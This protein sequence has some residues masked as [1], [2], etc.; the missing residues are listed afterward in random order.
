LHLKTAG[1]FEKSVTDYSKMSLKKRKS[2]QLTDK[3]VYIVSPLKLQ[4]DLMA[5]FLNRET[6]AKC[7]VGKD[8]RH[9]PATDNENIGQ[10]KLVLLDCLGKDRESFLVELE[11]D[12]RNINILHKNLVAL[13]NVNPG[14]RI[15]EK[16][17]ELGLRG[18][19][20]KKD[21]L[22]RITKG[23]Y[24]IFNGEFWLSR[25]IM[26]KCLRK[27]KVRR[28]PIMRDRINVTTREIEVLAMVA[29][30]GQK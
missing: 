4:N 29:L 9:I 20:Y 17:V 12:G 11:S 1:Y 10:P 25:G 19:F 30:R 28:N 8:L 18:F 15:E 5:L 21:N 16:A 14:W 22:D 13:F 23:V 24:A 2:R 6:G 3:L 26:A 7:L 27:Y